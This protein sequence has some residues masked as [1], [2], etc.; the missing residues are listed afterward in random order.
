MEKKLQKIYVTYYKCLIEQDLWQ[1]HYRILSMIFLKE[2]I[3]LNENSDTL[4]K[5]C[6]TCGIKYTY[7]D[8]FFEYTNVKNDLIKTN[9]CVVPIIIK[10]SLTKS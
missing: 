6:E 5:K 8:C 10:T 2:F 9:V 1:T 4:I 7:S 3:E